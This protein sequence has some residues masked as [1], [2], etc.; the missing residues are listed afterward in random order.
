MAVYQV[1][2]DGKTVALNCDASLEPYA[3]WLLGEIA[4]QHEAG[5]KVF[6]GM[7]I[8]VG[9]SMV[10]L[11]P[12]EGVLFLWEPDFGNDPLAGARADVTSTLSVYKQQRELLRLV[13]L[14]EGQPARFDETL[15]VTL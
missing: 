12:L 14:D 4:R 15:V 10:I 5:N 9:W 8:Q 3:N 7:F 1:Q 6:E 13:G 2:L 11:R